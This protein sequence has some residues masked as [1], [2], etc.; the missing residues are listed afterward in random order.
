[1][2]SSLVKK[3]IVVG[4]VLLGAVGATVFLCLHMQPPIIA[5]NNPEPNTSFAVLSTTIKIP[6]LTFASVE[7]S[8]TTVS[9][10]VSLYHIFT[11]DV[12]AAKQAN[13]S[14]I[15]LQFF[16]D[17]MLDRNVAKSMGSRGLDYIFAKVNC[18]PEPGMTRC[19]NRMFGAA[20]ILIANLEG[21]F[22]PTRVFTTK[23]IAFRFDPKWAK[24]LKHY[25]FTAFTLANNHT[26]D[27]GAANSNFTRKVLAENGINYFGQEY[28][29]SPS[30]TWY[31][32]STPPHLPF[33]R[34]GQLS[35]PYEG[36]DQGVVSS[37]V[38]LPATIAFIGIE[39]VDHPINKAQVLA[40][41]NE[42][43]QKTRYIIV[44]VHGGVEYKRI[45][46][47]AQRTL[48]HW[49]IDNGATAVIGHHP[50]VVEEMEMYKGAPIFYSLGN[51]IFDQYFSKDTQEGLSV[52][53]T[54]QDGGVKSVYLFPFFGVKSQVQL[55]TGER[56]DGFL[57][58]MEDN[59]RLDG[60]TITNG[61]VQL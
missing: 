37:S 25:G 60:H 19:D 30:L 38:A 52:G 46:T 61:K 39:T 29:E 23:S 48:Y 5:R 50:H 22:A 14:T 47:K 41:L 35:P 20:D 3:L 2:P 24:Q 55:M 15:S 9:S 1:M 8:L 26:M 7:N 40:A 42:A 17:M 56:R 54:L 34:G 27:M 11:N 45:S 36:G 51:F 53:L 10:T 59:S 33:V 4:C 58:W 6:I 18:H 21:P 13:S 12:I 31:A 32:T 28:K 16:G 44:N 57:K 43:K 49:L